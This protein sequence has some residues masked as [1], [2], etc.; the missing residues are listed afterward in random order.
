MAAIASFAILFSALLWVFGSL[1]VKT[2]KQQ[3]A[4]DECQ[5]TAFGGRD[6]MKRHNCLAKKAG[7]S[8]FFMPAILAGGRGRGFY[9]NCDGVIGSLPVVHLAYYH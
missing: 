9:F 6:E 8:R 3:F 1:I 4:G 2:I 5:C 7:E